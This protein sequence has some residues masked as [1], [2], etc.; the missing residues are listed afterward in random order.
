MLHYVE[1]PA[2]RVD[3]FLTCLMEYLMPRAL[4]IGVILVAL[5]SM[6]SEAQTA[7]RPGELRPRDRGQSEPATQSSAVQQRT[8]LAAPPAEPF[9]FQMGM[10]AARLRSMGARPAEGQSHMYEIEN[11]PNPHNEFEQYLLMAS[12]TQGLCKVTAIGRNVETSAFG[13]QLRSRFDSMREALQGKYGEPGNV[14]DFVRSGSLWDEP[15]YFMMGL[16]RGDRSL[17]A[18]WGGEGNPMSSANLHA[19]G[20]S[21]KALRT[22]TGYLT[23]TYEFSNF[24]ACQEEVQRS[25]S[26]PL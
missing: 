6:R 1:V 26:D 2:H 16:S 10:S 20:L 3:F 11:A 24:G 9:G 22:T 8:G 15:Q 23:L 14:F 25:S 4:T 13:H 21:A 18:F 5:A 19:I 12:P 7:G 17:I